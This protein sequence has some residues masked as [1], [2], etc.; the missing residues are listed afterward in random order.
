MYSRVLYE[1]WHS[2]VPIVA[3]SVTFT[4][5]TVAFMRSL[6]MRKEKADAMAAKPLD[7][8]ATFNETLN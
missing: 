5:F 4:V 6:V 2:I 7:E 3:F 1:D 8:G